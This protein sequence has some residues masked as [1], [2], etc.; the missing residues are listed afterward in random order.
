MNFHGVVFEPGAASHCQFGRLR[1]FVE[2]QNTRVKR[3]SAVFSA[4][5]HRKLNMI[6]GS[7]FHMQEITAVH[8]ENIAS[9]ELTDSD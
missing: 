4:D 2:L 9:P 6:D 8:S 7:Y 5:R 1:L 3:T